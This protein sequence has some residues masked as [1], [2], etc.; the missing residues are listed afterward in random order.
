[1]KA[2]IIAMYRS[3]SELIYKIPPIEVKSILDAVMASRDPQYLELLR[4]MCR[5]G[6]NIIYH[7]QRIIIAE[8]FQNYSDAIVKTTYK[9]PNGTVHLAS[10]LTRLVMVETERGPVTLATFA[11]IR[12]KQGFPPEEVNYLEKLLVRLTL[13]N[14]SR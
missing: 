9:A 3:D 7:N 8:L 6:N 1:M 4:T 14:I 2:L 13:L 12:G 11:F 10:K 5:Y